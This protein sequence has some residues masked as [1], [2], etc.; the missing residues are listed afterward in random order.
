MTM[1]MVHSGRVSIAS[2]GGS[3]TTTRMMLRAVSATARSIKPGRIAD[4]GAATRG[5]YTLVTRE[6]LLTRLPVI[7]STAPE[8]YVQTDSPQNANHW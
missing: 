7:A 3:P 5:K 4:N 1:A 2:P 8:E 6:A